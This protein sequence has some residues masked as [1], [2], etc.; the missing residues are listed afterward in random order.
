MESKQIAQTREPAQKQQH[1]ARKAAGR[2]ESRRPVN[3]QVHLHCPAL[4]LSPWLP[5]KACSQLFETSLFYGRK[6]RLKKVGLGASIRGKAQ[7][8]H[9]RGEIDLKNL[10]LHCK[11]SWEPYTQFGTSLCC[12]SKS[13][14]SA[15]QAHSAG[16][17]GLESDLPM[18]GGRILY[19]INKRI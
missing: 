9:H 4:S 16:R 15:P 8:S 12:I 5:C 3:A 7:S 2:G 1:L 6:L 18:T 14:K 10:L 17:Q 11:T 19:G 13:S